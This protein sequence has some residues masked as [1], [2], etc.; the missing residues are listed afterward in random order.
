MPRRNLCARSDMPP[1]ALRQR[2][3]LYVIAI[4]LLLYNLAG[5]IVL[6]E[7]KV[8]G[9][10]PVKLY[11]PEILLWAAWVG[12]AYFW[13]RFWL[14]SEA[15]PIGDFVEDF[16]WQL[17]DTRIVRSIAACHVQGNAHANPTSRRDQ[18]LRKGGPIPL[19]SPFGFT[20]SL[21]S[22]RTRKGQGVPSNFGPAN[23][24]IQ[25]QERGR[26]IWAHVLAFARAIRCERTFTDHT[27][28]HLFA[29]VTVLVGLARFST[30][31]FT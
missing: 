6:D 9:L 24:E 17:G 8:S 5:G 15:R 28:P 14:V 22:L 18:L 2:R 4:G 10:L 25:R 21:N 26:Y 16:G 29:A 3:D 11:R 12:L 31:Y 1:D 20:L 30:R 27:L 7:T 19:V 23:I 13:W